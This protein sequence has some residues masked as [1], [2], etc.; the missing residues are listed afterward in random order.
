LQN[1]YL[2]LAAAMQRICSRQKLLPHS[3][4]L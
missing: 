1:L 3:V 4:R 2:V